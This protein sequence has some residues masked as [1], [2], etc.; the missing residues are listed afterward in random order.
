[1]GDAATPLMALGGSSRNLM[2]YAMMFND[3]DR[4]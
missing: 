3:P 4:Y 2:F 1:M